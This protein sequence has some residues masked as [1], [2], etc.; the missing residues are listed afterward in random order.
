MNTS[1][2]ICLV[3]ETLT[4]LDW[5]VNNMCAQGYEIDGESFSYQRS[6][7]GIIVDPTVMIAQCMMKRDGDSK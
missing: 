2:H 6:D 3:A 5:A 1:K 7:R 4:D